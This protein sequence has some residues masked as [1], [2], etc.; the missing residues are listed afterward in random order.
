MEIYHESDQGFFCDVKPLITTQLVDH[1][2]HDH[3]HQ[4]EKSSSPHDRAKLEIN[5]TLF[6]YNKYYVNLSEE[7]ETQSI[8]ICQH[9]EPAI[10]ATHTIDDVRSLDTELDVVKL[11]LSEQ[12]YQL[13]IEDDEWHDSV[14]EDIIK[15]GREIGK[16]DSKKGPKILRLRAPLSQ[17]Q[18]DKEFAAQL[19][20]L[21]SQRKGK[22]IVNEGEYSEDD[23]EMLLAMAISIEERSNSSKPSSSTGSTHQ[24]QVVSDTGDDESDDVVPAVAEGAAGSSSNRSVGRNAGKNVDRST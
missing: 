22:D 15:G 8:A 18:I 19:S 23:F 10:T 6:V 17:E 16:S 20:L 13:K 14:V 1:P 3:D 21:D 24:N 9:E 5:F 2:D 4:N 12:L 7:D 11:F